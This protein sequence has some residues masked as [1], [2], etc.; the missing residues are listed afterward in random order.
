M[1]KLVLTKDGSHTLYNTDLDVWHHSVNG[2][3]QE[4]MRVFIELG[5]W[6]KLQEKQTI[7]IFEMGLGTGLNVLLTALE[8]QKEQ[9]NI[10]YEVI[11]AYPIG[12]EEIAALNYGEIFSTDLLTKI[13]EAT[14][15]Q[16]VAIDT[17]FQLKK[18]QQDLLQ[19]DLGN[20]IDLI[21]YDAF[22]PTTQ[23]ELWTEEVFVKLYNAMN[24]GGFLTTYCSKTVVRKALI[25][26]GFKVE[27]HPGPYGK[28]EVLRAVKE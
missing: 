7:K 23:P 20:N 27:K 12:Q 25:A 17:G 24:K 2:A 10:V 28:R 16:T 4:S 22:S 14:W 19:Y 5:L 21:F 26:A 6:P 8:A 15:E 3:V 11:E 18:V 9:T 13:H 1:I